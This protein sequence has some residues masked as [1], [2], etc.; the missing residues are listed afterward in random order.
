MDNYRNGSHTVYTL[1]IHLVWI[2]KYH[3]KV[4]S[5]TVA[6]RLRELIRERCKLN[7]VDILKGH[8]SKDHIHVFVSMP[9]HMSVS[10]LVQYLKGKTS[11]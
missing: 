4:L 10:K 3:K 9:P 7:E 1:K 11:D 2:T 6:D 8:I 5:G